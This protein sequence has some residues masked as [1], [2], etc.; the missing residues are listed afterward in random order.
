M[1]EDRSHRSHR[2]NPRRWPEG[3]SYVNNLDSNVAAS[4]SAIALLSPSEM[5]FIQDVPRLLGDGSYANLGHARGGSAILMASTMRALNMKYSRVYSV[6]LFPRASD[7]R[8]AQ[9][10]IDQFEVEG[11]INL[12]A[13][14]TDALAERFKLPSGIH[15][16]NFVFIDADHTYEAVKRDYLNWSP[17]V[18][19]GGWISFHDTNQDFSHNAIEEVVTWPELKDYHVDRIRTFQRPL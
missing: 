5:Q 6:D 13:G 8:R 16:F 12:L 10:N 3:R 11:W 15:D 1:K 14:S 2:L 19:P 9:R 4:L 18:K 17:L 7:L